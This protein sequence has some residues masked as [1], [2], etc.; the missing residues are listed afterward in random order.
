MNKVKIFVDSTVD[1]SKE[2][3]EEYDFEVL[4]LNVNFGTDNFKDGVDMTPDLLYK[5]VK[6]FGELPSTAALSHL[7]S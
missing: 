3:Y 6:E 2:L 7:I 4:P 1:L 5:R